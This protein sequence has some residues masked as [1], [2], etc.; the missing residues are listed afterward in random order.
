[1]AA[2]RNPSDQPEP[3]R[4]ALAGLRGAKFRPEIIVQESP[5]PPTL[6]PFAAALSGEVAIGEEE[7]SSGRLVLLHDPHGEA[8]W[9]G[10][11]RF[12]LL[13][14]A[15]LEPELASDEL[16]PEVGWAWLREALIRQGT[17][18]TGLS[19]TVTRVMSQSFGLRESVPVAGQVEIRAS[20]TAVSTDFAAHAQV[21]ADVLAEAAGLPPLPAGVAA[22]PR[23]R[24]LADHLR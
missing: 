7:G 6:A 14:R 22:L 23:Q 11:F 10:T 3:F 1:M 12:V 5:A 2:P 13:V 16:L 20:W 4:L 17:E 8:E 15:E 9:L 19:G 24:R 18:V 21:W